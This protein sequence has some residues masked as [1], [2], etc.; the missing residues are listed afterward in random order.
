VA[1]ILVVGSVAQDDLVWL[2]QPLREGRHLNGRQGRPRLG[3]GGAN[4]AIPLRQAGHDVSLIAAVGSD[5]LAEWL[6]A[7]LQQAGLDVSAVQRAAG[8]STHSLVLLDRAGERTVVNLNRCREDGPPVRLRAQPADALYV[9]S[10]ELDL[11]PLLAECVSSTL[12]V[13]HIPPIEHGSRPA[14]VLIGSASDLSPEF[15]AAPWDAG[16][17]IAGDALRW[18]VVTRGEHGAQAWSAEGCL[19]VAAPRVQVVDTT[20]AGDAFVGAFAAQLSHGAEPAAALVFG[21]AAGDVGIAAL[22]EVSEG[23][24]R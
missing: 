3:G 9:R 22:F 21:C 24:A 19:S 2:E 14:T 20:G 18:V 4:T 10:R 15:L 17:S 23:G 12:V 13:A 1:R 6:L 8:D 7:K 5:P 16:R 11:A